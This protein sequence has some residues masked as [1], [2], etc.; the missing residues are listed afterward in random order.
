[1]IIENLLPLPTAQHLEEKISNDWFPWYW[2]ES[3]IDTYHT[4]EYNGIKNFQFTHHFYK[5]GSPSSSYATMLDPILK[6]LE[7][8]TEKRIQSIFRVKA[9]LVT[10]M[11]MSAEELNKEIHIDHFSDQ[12]SS[13]VYYVSDSDG[14][15]VVYDI[16]DKILE[17]TDPVFNTGILFKSNLR[18]R[19][20]PP[21][22]HKR[23][24]VLNFIME[25]K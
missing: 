19:G 24:I 9:N 3:T 25:M 12:Y 16:D 14:K 4:D 7:K 1:M 17:Q 2:T 22:L 8:R 11:Q 13:F 20:T 18:H 5:N 6:E 23:R 10:N 21:S 15:T